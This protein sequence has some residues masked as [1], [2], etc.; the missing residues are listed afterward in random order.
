MEHRFHQR[1]A[2]EAD[3]VVF[4]RGNQVA[5]CRTQDLSLGGA[6][7][8]TGPLS[9]CR[10]TP[11]EVELA[12]GSDTRPSRHRLHAF[13]VHT[14]HDGAGLMFINTSVEIE[15]AI[16]G[17]QPTRDGGNTTRSMLPESHPTPLLVGT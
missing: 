5:T 4:H 13:V 17:A 12:L 2:V 11:L 6:F 1:R 9:F 7:I 8:R 10:H 16:R 15:A 14:R 3:A